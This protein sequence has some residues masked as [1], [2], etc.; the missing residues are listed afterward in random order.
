MILA[1]IPY[2]FIRK[3]VLLSWQDVLWGYERQLIGWSSVVDLAENRV[4]RGAD[5][6]T[7]IELASLGKSETQKVGELLRVLADN[8]S[9][10]ADSTADKKWL[11]LVLAWLFEKRADVSDPLNEI[12]AIYADFDYPSEIE[13]LVGYM[14]TTDGYDPSQ[15]STKEN[16]ARLFSRWKQYLSEA[17]QKIGLKIDC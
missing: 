17:E 8:E 13:M 6:P 1:P 11:F 12:E 9:D 2:S 16:K 3:H 10:E 15:H 14:P 7:E 4:L 5:N